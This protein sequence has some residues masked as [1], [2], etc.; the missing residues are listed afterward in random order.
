MLARTSLSAAAVAAAA[1]LAG[2]ASARPSADPTRQIRYYQRR[3]EEHP[4]LYPAWVALGA[5]HLERAR[6]THD[7]SDLAA[8]RDAADRALAIQPNLEAY[9]LRAAAAGFAHR[10]E[11]ALSWADRAAEAAPED[12]GITALRVEAYV[13]LGR[14]EEAR[15]LL[16]EDGRP[17]RQFHTAAALGQWFA[18]EGRPDRAEAAFEEAARLARAAGVPELEAWSEVRSAGVWLDSGQPGP[19]RAH[20]ARAAQI[21]PDDY[22]LAVHRAELDAAE[23][24]DAEALRRFER[25]LRDRDDPELHR[26]AFLVSRRLGRKA[27]ARR[28]FEA[29]EALDRR[30]LDAGEIYTLEALARLYC[31][32]GVHLEE[33]RRLAEENLRY[34]RDRSARRALECVEEAVRRPQAGTASSRASKRPST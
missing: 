17:L 29:A 4:R 28:H 14:D 27:D 23:G 5:A 7:P 2:C 22:Q 33:A 26:R 15:R 19:A 21:A 11:E 13:G 3:V 6:R 8:A 20:L 12:A 31:D 9:R 18:A 32:A 30:V 34:K 10:F 16:P 24:R 1:L 25:L